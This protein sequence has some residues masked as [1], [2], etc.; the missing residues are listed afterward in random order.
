MDPFN[1]LSTDAAT[2]KIPPL[3]EVLHTKVMS[4][5]LVASIDLEKD[6]D[7]T[8]EVGEGVSVPL[9]K[10]VG[11]SANSPGWLAM[12]CGNAPPPVLRADHHQR[13]K[14]PLLPEVIEHTLLMLFPLV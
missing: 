2:R 1:A 11:L 13:T 10:M 8:K 6:L 9:A 7:D 4:C 3:K 12:V 14:V 5:A